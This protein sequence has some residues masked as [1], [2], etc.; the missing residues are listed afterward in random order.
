MN[1]V[2]RIAF[3]IPFLFAM[4]FTAHQ[5][6]GFAAVMGA[7]EATKLLA[8]SQ[9]LEEKC[10]F[11]TA[12]QHE[13]L[14]AF[15]AKAEIAMVAK[16]SA[17]TARTIIAT[18]RAT[19]IN[20]ACTGAEHA[21]IVNIISAA[22]QATSGAAQSNPTLARVAPEKAVVVVTPVENSKTTKPAQEITKLF[23]DRIV[24]K[25]GLGRYAELIQRYYLARRCNTMSQ[26]PITSLYRDV[27]STHRSVVSSFGVPA[28]RSVMN[29]SEIKAKASSCV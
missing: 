13:E 3:A 25:S 9:A 5:S 22:H 12:S 11:L 4:A 18:G 19:G 29:Q 28:V 20:A 8:R 15:V 2:N 27:V 26:G 24:L 17:A 6:Q 1:F 14:S 7:D 10:K 23:S 21:D 16:S